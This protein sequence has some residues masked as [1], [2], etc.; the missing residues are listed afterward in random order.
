MMTVILARSVVDFQTG[1]LRYPAKSP[2]GGHRRQVRRLPLVTQL[3]DVG[4]LGID[5]DPIE[6][7]ADLDPGFLPRN[8]DAWS[9]A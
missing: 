6:I 1:T 7:L 9:A 2:S 5:L 3:V 4:D 8:E